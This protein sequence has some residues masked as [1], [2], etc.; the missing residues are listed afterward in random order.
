MVYSQ[1]VTGPNAPWKRKLDSCACYNMHT[2]N[3]NLVLLNLVLSL[4]IPASSG[5]RTCLAL[6][7]HGI[8]ILL[9]DP[10]A[11]FS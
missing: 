6:L 9:D 10:R 5:V 1:L 7:L 3:P 11:C 4:L 8:N 2:T